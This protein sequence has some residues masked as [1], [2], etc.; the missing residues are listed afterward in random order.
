MT[1]QRQDQREATNVNEEQKESETPTGT[2]AKA[3]RVTGLE[4]PPLLL[5]TAGPWGAPEC[6]RNGK[7]DM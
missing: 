5:G 6:A 4:L 7:T 3:D 2:G 1:Q